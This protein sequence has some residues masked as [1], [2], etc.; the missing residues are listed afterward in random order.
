MN[1]LGL[2]YNRVYFEGIT[3]R[4]NGEFVLEASSIMEEIKREKLDYKSSSL[5][6]E[7]PV[8]SEN[9]V[10]G[11]KLDYE[12]SSLETTQTFKLKT[13]YPGLLYGAGYQ[14]E[15][16]GQ[17]N[18]FKLGFYFDYT[19][20]LPIINGSSIKGVLRAG[21]E[22]RKGYIT[23]ILKERL[24]IDLPADFKE[25]EFI[26]TV[27]EG[28][29]TSI[30]QRDIFFEATPLS[31]EKTLLG[32]DYITTHHENPLQ[33]PNPVQ[34]LRIN[35]EVTYQFQF[36]LKESNGLTADHKKEL[37]KQIILDLGV[38][39][40][41]NVGYGQF[42]EVSEEALKEAQRKEQERKER[43][44]KQREQKRIR[45]EKEQHPPYRACGSRATLYKKDDRVEVTIIE[46]GAYVRMQDQEGSIFAK[47]KE[48]IIKKFNER[49]EKKRKKK[50]N[51][52][53]KEL[54]RG[55]KVTIRFNEDLTTDRVNFT[56][57]PVIAQ[58]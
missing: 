55:M 27:F 12:I 13:V 2:L 14:H 44:E 25:K 17:Q 31:S 51:I 53:F 20:G 21:C 7:T 47:S 36:D 16:G 1:N 19:R 4:Q 40:K 32:S 50:P 46:E 28:K 8:L 38:G 11:E 18:E 58:E 37:F 41:T 3:F 30:Y 42:E 10:F 39:A 49:L 56:V 54:E 57:L 33:D 34:F 48:N 5:E 9:Q 23:T 52:Q 45:E 29:D 22:S 15:I 26:K 24:H 6:T 35:G 43:E